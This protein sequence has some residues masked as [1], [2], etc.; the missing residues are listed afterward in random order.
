MLSLDAP[1]L[2]DVDRTPHLSVVPATPRKMY[3]LIQV[4]KTSGQRTV[5][6][7][8]TTDNVISL[9]WEAYMAPDC[10]VVIEEWM[11]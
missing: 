6:Y 5:I 1:V 11:P 3:S 8:H 4:H 9:Y 7:E 10:Y 2:I